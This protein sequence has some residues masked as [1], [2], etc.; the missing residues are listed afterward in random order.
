MNRFFKFSFIVLS[1]FILWSCQDDSSLLSDNGQEQNEID[2]SEQSLEKS[3]HGWHHSEA[4]Y[5]VTVEN[6]TPQT[7]DGSSQPFSPPVLATHNNHYRI[8]NPGRYASNELAQLAEDAANDPLIQKLKRSKRVYDVAM[9]GGVIVPGA[10]TTIRIASNGYFKR[11]SLVSML[12]NT[13]DGFTG[14]NS[15]NLPK[16][17]SKSFYVYAYDAGSE[18]NTESFDHIP[19]PCCDSHFVRVPTRER[20]KHHKGILGI[21]DLDPAIYGWKKAVAKVTITRIYE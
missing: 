17:G 12:V 20:I 5:D 10:S 19:G 6:I 15:V 16:K 9:G 21:A 1:F 3:N 11:L 7:G 8:F 4:L 2:A 13:N 18:K 14:V